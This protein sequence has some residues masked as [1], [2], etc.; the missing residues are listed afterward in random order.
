MHKA[1]ADNA[2]GIYSKLK[3]I[4]NPPNYTA[5]TAAPV[6]STSKKQQAKAKSVATI[7][8]EEEKAVALNSLRSRKAWDLAMGP[9]KQIPM[10]VRRLFICIQVQS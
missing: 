1:R 10:Q 5:P 2:F 3:S 9:A 7:E 6:A 4:P 8:Q